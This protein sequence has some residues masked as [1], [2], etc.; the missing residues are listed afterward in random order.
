[1]SVAACRR[2]R[3]WCPF[4]YW[5]RDF[6][7]HWHINWDK[8]WQ[9]FLNC[10]LIVKYFSKAL[11]YTNGVLVVPE[12]LRSLLLSDMK[13]NFHSSD[14]SENIKILGLLCHPALSYFQFEVT[15]KAS[16]SKFTK[17]N[18][19]SPVH[20]HIHIHHYGTLWAYHSYLKNLHAASYGRIIFSG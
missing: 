16:K 19:L 11:Q 18:V 1:M 10:N 3:L 5:N 7:C 17:W 12:F 8:N 4:C 15:I 2:E 14:Y 13:Q 20:Y 9:N 6:C